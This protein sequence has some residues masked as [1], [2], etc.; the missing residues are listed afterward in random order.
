MTICAPKCKEFSGGKSLQSSH[1][2]YSNY[3]AITSIVLITSTKLNLARVQ[4]II[5]PH[6]R[7][8]FPLRPPL[9]APTRLTRNHASRPP[10]VL[11]VVTLLEWSEAGSN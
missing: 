6:D 5:R 1:S 8:Y 10:D 11:S 9:S 2:T 7:R 4:K 3:S